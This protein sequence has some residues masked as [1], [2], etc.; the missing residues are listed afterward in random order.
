MRV[1]ITGATGFIGSAIVPELVAAGHAVTALVRSPEGAAQVAA[2]G[3]TPR[4][5]GLTDLASLRAAAAEADAVIHCAFNHRFSALDALGSVLVQLTRSPY[6]GRVSRAGGTDVRAVEAMTAGLAENGSATKVL[7]STG[8]IA[9]LKAGRM[10]TEEDLLDPGALGGIRIATEL[11]T[12]GATKR[13]VQSASIRLP[14]SVHGA[15][16]HGFVPTLMDAARR[17]GVS[18][19]LGSGDNRWPAVHRDDAAVLY[20]L[21]MEGLAAGALAGGTVLHGVADEGVPFKDIADAVAV[22]L[23]LGPAVPRKRGHFPMF[24]GMMAGL[25]LPAS[26]A[27]TRRLTGWQPTRAGLV[28][29]V[30]SAAYAGATLAPA[31]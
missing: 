22:Q 23:G 4:Q 15:G 28:A 10:G 25:D 24:V 29:D 30:R 11:A 9:G 16:D 26:S 1:F 13:G 6:F 2:A 3:A 21:A 20:R 8:P 31:V 18:A 27:I 17:A 19:Y 7:V 5:G 14:P 12:L